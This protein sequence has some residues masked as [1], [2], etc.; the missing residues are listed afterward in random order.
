MLVGPFSITSNRSAVF[1]ATVPVR[2]I[3]YTFIY[4]NPSLSWRNQIFQFLVTFDATT[5]ALI[6]VSAAIVGASLAVL[7]RIKPGSTSYTLR[8]SLLFAFGYLFQGV[9]TRPPTYASSQILIIVWW[10]FCLILVIAF[11]ANYAAFR[12][13]NALENLPNSPITLLHQ[14]YFKYAYIKESNMGYL[15]GKSLDS[16][17]YSLYQM[18]NTKFK[19]MIP[20]SRDEGINEVIKGKFALLDESPFSEYYARKYCLKSSP[21]LWFGTYV[22]FMPKK[23][24]YGAII[25]EEIKK[26]RSDGTLEKIYKSEENKMMSTLPTYCGAM[27]EDQALGAMLN[28]LIDWSDYSVELAT[29]VGIFIAS[30]IGLLIVLITLLVEY[31]LGIYKEAMIDKDCHPVIL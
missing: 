7:H 21:S 19:Y 6:F 2:S 28:P 11:C 16:A 30:L 3:S 17:I 25:S 13:F 15:M 18:I 14:K 12:S 23:L 22:F 10:L 9:R 1:Q 20:N 26:M 4:R 24:S 29:A 31:L 27:L 5:W 8:L